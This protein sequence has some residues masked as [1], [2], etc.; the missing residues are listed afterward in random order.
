MFGPGERTIPRETV[1][2]PTNP[3][4][5]GGSLPERRGVMIHPRGSTDVPP[6]KE[7]WAMDV[8]DDVNLDSSQVEDRGYGGGGGFPGGGVVIGGGGG[9]VGLIVLVLIFVLNNV[10]GVG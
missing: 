4:S 10:G 1:A 7:L 3:F 2:T 5:T 8:R 6:R 9:I